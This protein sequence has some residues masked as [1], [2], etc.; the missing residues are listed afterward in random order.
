[1]K[2]FFFGD[3]GD[4]S[5]DL[6]ELVKKVKN[7]I[8]NEDV[9]IL[10]GDNFYSCGVKSIDD[11][12]WNKFIETFNFNNSIYSILGNH[13]YQYNPNCQ[14]EF[15]KN[16]WTFPN[17]YYYFGLNNY[18]QIWALDTCQLIPFGDC[19]LDNDWGC[20]TEKK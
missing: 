6:K 3:I 20:V 15:K 8:S 17:H 13:D 5:K 12:L 16:N 1:M 10:L 7:E 2:L 18:T 14:I 9:I 19:E 11:P 4:Y